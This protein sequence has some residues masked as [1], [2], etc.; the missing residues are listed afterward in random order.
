MSMFPDATRAL[1]KSPDDLNAERTGTLREIYSKSA[2]PPYGSG[3]AYQH[4]VG[5]SPVT[6]ATPSTETP[7][8]E[9]LPPVSLHAGSHVV[10]QHDPLSFSA[11]LIHQRPVAAAVQSVGWNRAGCG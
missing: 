5:G 7:E 2:V 11:R 1:L 9:V 10:R 3:L 4:V 8:P 6:L